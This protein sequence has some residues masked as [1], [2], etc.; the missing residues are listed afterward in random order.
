M[1]AII[2]AQEPEQQPAARSEA[3]GGRLKESR[4]ESCHERQS[5]CSSSRHVGCLGGS[6]TSPLS[7]DAALG[8]KPG[9]LGGAQVTPEH[10]PR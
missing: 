2:S 5:H 6:V 10:W 7:S 8:V 1:T 4:K 9:A 3:V